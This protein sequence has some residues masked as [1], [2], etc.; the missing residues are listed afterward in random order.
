VRVELN[1]QLLA[2]AR[3]DQTAAD[4]F[5]GGEY[6]GAFS[7][8]LCETVRALGVKSYNEVMETTS[9]TIR[10]EGYSQV[11]Q[12]EGPFGEEVLFG[13]SVA[14][15][16]DPTKVSQ[17]EFVAHTA[18]DPV[19][20]APETSVRREPLS[21][22]ADWLRVSE[23]VID[24]AGERSAAVPHRADGRTAG[25][26]FVVYV[27]GISRHRE[28]YSLP[29][30]L[31]MQPYLSRAIGR[32]EVLWSPLVNPRAA[33]ALAEP[34]VQRFVEEIEQELERRSEAQERLVPTEARGSRLQRPRGSGL[35]VDDF[36]RYML[37]ES[38][39][40][41]VLHVFDD[42]VRPLLTAG[43]KIHLIAHSWGTVVSYEGLR[44][45]DA[46]TFPGQV[47]NLFLVGSALS[48]APVRSNLFGRVSDGRMPRVVRRVVNLDA[49]GDIVGG[50]IGE[51]FAVN[52]EFLGLAPTGCSTIIFTNIALNPSCAHSS[53]FDS[54]N[55][56]VNRDVFAHFIDNS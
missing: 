41:A 43:K 25:D 15:S 16:N 27:H 5:I 24:L 29:W 35:S 18:G 12:N 23:K 26:E 45:L 21:L 50:A 20:S 54:A 4:A 34:E 39:R 30:F 31:A 14:P 6:N 42:V 47:A 19:K 3:D 53:Y 38:T 13:G 51:H 52:R 40:E 48:I 49:G 46:A 11:P 32:A 36:A 44:R 37:V 55:T 1:H 2:G 8:Y 17:G 28:G 10:A 33:T 22:L 56:E 9:R 7:Y